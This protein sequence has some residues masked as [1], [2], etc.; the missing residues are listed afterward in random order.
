MERRGDG[1]GFGL[2]SRRGEVYFK[3]EDQYFVDQK[4]H[5]YHHHHHCIIYWAHH[6]HLSSSIDPRTIT[7][8]F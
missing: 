4:Y 8:S 2:E 5:L 1:D 7:S 6:R 3:S